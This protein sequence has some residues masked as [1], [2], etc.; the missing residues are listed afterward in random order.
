MS[1]EG[2][3]ELLCK[4]GHYSTHD[5]N[6]DHPAVCV[7]CGEPNLYRHSVDQTNGYNKEYPSTCEAPKTEIGF[8]DDWREDHY[9][10]KYAVKIHL[11]E[12]VFP[13]WIDRAV[14]RAAIEEEIRLNNENRRWSIH[15]VDTE[16]NTWLMLNEFDAET[17]TFKFLPDVR[18]SSM[19]HEFKTREEADEAFL[20]I[21]IERRG[22][23]V[24]LR[25]G[26]PPRGEVFCYDL[27]NF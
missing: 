19:L 17:K 22:E 6:D 12:P 9:G 25:A 20:L 2:Y 11:Y 18:D 15:I 5:C 7:I 13:I 10:N 1:Y 16:K 14:E 21:E 27:R 24:R 23:A 4:K 3:E 26:T 8:E